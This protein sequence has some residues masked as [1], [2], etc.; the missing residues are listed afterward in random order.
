MPTFLYILFDVQ[1]FVIEPVFIVLTMLK[2]GSIIVTKKR[3]KEKTKMKRFNKF[4]SVL[5][6][7]I[8]VMSVFTVVPFTASAVADSNESTGIVSG[9]SGA[10]NTAVNIPLL[11]I[12]PIPAF[13]M[14]EVNVQFDMIVK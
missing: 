10:D 14:D 7:I 1:T 8:I 12:V 5:F 4:F 6:A 11:S 3:Y 9:D 13:T 2:M